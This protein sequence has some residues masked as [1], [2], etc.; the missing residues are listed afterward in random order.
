MKIRALCLT[1]LA[2]A[3]FAPSANAAVA[4]SILPFY[5]AADGVRAVKRAS[6]EDVIRF[7]AKAAKLYKAIA[8][9]TAEISCNT[10]IVRNDAGPLDVVGAGFSSTRKLPKRRGSVRLGTTK[11]ELC[12]IATK[13]VKGEELCFAPEVGSKLC[14]RVAVALT[15][16]GTAYL[17]E[18]ARTIELAFTASLLGAALS[19]DFKVPGNTTLEKMHTLLGPDVVELA[20]PDESPALGKVGFWA[21]DAKNFAIV[22]LLADG[23]RRFLSIRD[24]VFSTNDLRLTEGLDSEDVFTLG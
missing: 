2:S 18:R 12:A 16:A 22:A 13:K 8:G 4:D 15:P 19:P 10:R 20:T 5:D 6:G 11:A 21:P 1:L 14:V 3:C 17:D 23:T 7:D 24:G 9:K